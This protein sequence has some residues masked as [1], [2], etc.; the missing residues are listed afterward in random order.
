MKK[1]IL[2]LLALVMVLSLCACGGTTE[3]EPTL[4]PTPEA[5]PEPEETILKVGDTAKG[6]ICDVTV[7]SVENLNKIENGLLFHMWSPAERT[8][9]QDVT[10]EN[11]YSIIKIS[12]HFDYKGKESGRFSVNF[13]I[14]YDDGYLFTSGA[15]HLMPA[16]ESGIGFER[17]YDF[18]AT[19]IFEI[20]DPLNYKGEDAVTYIVVNDTVITEV[21]KE[22]LLKVDVPTL[23]DTYEP[24]PGGIGLVETQADAQTYTFDLRSVDF[25]ISLVNAADVQEEPARYENTGTVVGPNNGLPSLNEIYGDNSWAIKH[26]DNP[27]R[28]TVFFRE[29]VDLWDRLGDEITFSYIYSDDGHAIDAYIVE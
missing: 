29:D 21:E 15:N 6:E 1:V 23:P 24:M 10:A 22:L 12:Y 5:T 3:P 7:T 14:D 18:L 20:D 2:I 25:D 28:E 19:N 13:V 16:A 27:V 17:T 9:Y 26:G 4:E 8:D 11:G